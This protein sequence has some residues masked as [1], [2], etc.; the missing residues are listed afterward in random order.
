VEEH[1]VIVVGAGSAGGVVAAR[2]SEDPGRR[3]LLLE[4]GPDYGSEVERQP[5]AVIDADD[6]TATDYDW[7]HLAEP[8]SL[9]RR[10]PVFA[11]KIVGGSSATNN[12]MALRGH[13]ADYDGWAAAGNPGWA[14]DD[15]L[16]AFRRLERD[17]DYADRH[18]RAGPIAVGRVPRSRLAP[19]Q[20][21]FL[22]AC[23]AAGHA[24]VEDH[25]A[26]GAVGAG[27]LPLNQLDG[28]RQSVALT[29]LADARLRPNLKIRAEAPVDR[30]LL[31]DG[32]AHGVM[33]RGCPTPPGRSP[34]AR[35]ARPC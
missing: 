11:G 4:A 9:G 12:V 32:R 2:L 18:G 5:E 24:P 1:D 19:A 25:N 6:S 23:V 29:Y 3:V 35:R 13:P 17:L 14:F 7:G 26:P 15:V 20:A 30:V 16:D 10:I 34:R 21:A 33:L 8:E 28:V 27:P 22:D 31:D